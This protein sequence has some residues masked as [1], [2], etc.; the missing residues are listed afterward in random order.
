MTNGDKMNDYRKKN[1]QQIQRCESCKY[2]YVIEFPLAYAG[3]FNIVKQH[4]CDK[5][6]VDME[7]ITSCNLYEYKGAEL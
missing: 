3:H 1:E 2:H 4:R 5:T 7:H 6:K